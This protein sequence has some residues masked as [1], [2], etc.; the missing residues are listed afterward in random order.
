MKTRDGNKMI[1]ANLQF[2]NWILAKFPLLADYSLEK[3]Y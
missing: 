3:K 2:T 1:K